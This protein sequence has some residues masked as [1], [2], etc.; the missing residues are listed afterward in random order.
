MDPASHGLE[1]DSRSYAVLERATL[2][3]KGVPGLVCEI[4]TRRGGSA[5][6]IIDSLVR[7]GD[8]GRTLI[9]LDPYGNIEYATRQGVI[10]RI[11][12][13]NQMR[14]DTLRNLYA[15]AADKPV[16]VH[17][18]VL[19]DTEYFRRFADGFPT[20]D[21]NKTLQATYALVF[22]DGPHDIPSIKTEIDFFQPR[23]RPGSIWVFDD[24]THYDHDG[25][26]EPYLLK[27]GWVLVEKVWPKA[28]YRRT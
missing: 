5:R 28:S 13:T 18:L 8:H 26:V 19:E 6:V 27:I 1:A 14:N 21:Q 4:G 25:R 20:Y 7:N 9:C 16:N 10:C 12:Y 23:S 22:F 15:Y 24:I 11:D 17:L 2:A 3:I